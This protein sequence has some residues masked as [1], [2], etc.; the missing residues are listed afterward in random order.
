MDVGVVSPQNAWVLHEFL[1]LIVGQHMVDHVMQHGRRFYT[2]GLG[3][4]FMPVEFQGAACYRFVWPDE[5]TC[6][7]CGVDLEAARVAEEAERARRAAVI[8]EV[9][10]LIDAG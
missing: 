7:F 2:P 8:S 9:T 4:A 10:A 6:P 1:P 3:Q 5:R